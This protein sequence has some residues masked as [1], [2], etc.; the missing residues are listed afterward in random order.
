MVNKTE[1]FKPNLNLLIPEAILILKSYD[2]SRKY[3]NTF[4]EKVF[5]HKLNII[6]LLSCDNV[7][8]Q[9]VTKVH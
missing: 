2:I 8:C 9:Q 5:N 6:Q 3:E 7:R 1:I 4:H